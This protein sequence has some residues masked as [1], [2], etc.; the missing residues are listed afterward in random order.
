MQLPRKVLE[1]LIFGADLRRHTQDSP[2]LPDV[3]IA[4]GSE[5][6]PGGVDVLLEPKRGTTPATLAEAVRAFGAREVAF[7]DTHVVARVTL[8]ELVRELLPL[9]GWWST[10][11]AIGECGRALQ[12]LLAGPPARLAATIADPLAGVRAKTVHPTTDALWLLAI[13]GVLA[14]AERTRGAPSSLPP[15]SEYAGDLKRLFAGF[16]WKP[17]P[18]LLWAVN[19]NRAATVPLWQSTPTVKADAARRVFDVRGSSITWAVIDTGIDA[20]HPA[21]GRRDSSG[22][23]VTRGG[24][25]KN[26]RVRAT[27][28]FT[29]VRELFE[30]ESAF[31]KRVAKSTKE[32]GVDLQKR[33][34]R[35][36]DIDWASLLQAGAFTV[37]HDGKYRAPVNPHGTHVA[38][39]IG[40]EWKRGEAGYDDDDD[41]DLVGLCPE[42]DLIDIR[43]FGDA[44][45]GDEFSI[46]S[47]LQFV[48]FLKEHAIHRIDGVNLSVSIPHDVAN[49]AC[50]RTPVCDE[51]SRLVSSG[52]VAVA[53][54]GNRGYIKYL[55]AQGESDAY[56]NISITDPGNAEAV[57]TVGAVHRGRP[58]S[59]GVSYFSSRG[60]TGD[61]R[62][63]PDLVAPGEK[64]KSVGPDRQ[65]LSL[66]GTSQAAP[67]VSG[68]AALLM[69]VHREL[70]G[71]P[72]RVKAIL[73]NTATDIGRE[74]YFQG[75]GLVDVLRALQS[76]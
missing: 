15:P 8:A 11:I 44:G 14:W 25:A 71:D 34:L 53:A 31:A 20:R 61:G 5:D 39:I 56:R 54:A 76:V 3:W 55:T 18:G 62:I 47:A 26:T 73:C 23:L 70:A 58:H 19:R 49:Y 52:I 42:I 6:S 22:A 33:L 51:V 66:D 28:D 43:V 40:G 75:H 4:F 13:M 45:S 41:Y 27:Y 57:I 72:A 64:I 1:Q 17:R 50:G 24:W 35:G 67:H 68:A 37:A 9:S 46:I 74:R 60:P 7:H 2:V 69:C 63:K 16:S 12:R 38:G 36:Q 10:H 48:R 29:R 21:F 30:P 59:Y 32:Y 65:V